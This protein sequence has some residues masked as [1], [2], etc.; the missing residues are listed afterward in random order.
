MFNNKNNKV[1]KIDSIYFSDR[2]IKRI[3]KA[4]KEG[5]LSG[6]D[7]S[8]FMQAVLISEGTYIVAI[9]NYE[10]VNAE[11]ALRL[12][13][14]VEKHPLLW[15]RFFMMNT[16]SNSLI[17]LLNKKETTTIINNRAKEILD[18]A[19]KEGYLS[20]F[21]FSMFMQEIIIPEGMYVIDTGNYEN[22]NAEVA[23]RLARK[24]KKHPLLW[25]F[26][27]MVA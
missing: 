3:S 10:T 19:D 26:F 2:A 14:H 13:E 17:R 21:D 25:Q 20:G 16:E 4:H 23:L 9:G 8:V 12:I 24:I 5:Y 6:F 18:K 1:T 11:V 22:V 15:K 27:F 7:F